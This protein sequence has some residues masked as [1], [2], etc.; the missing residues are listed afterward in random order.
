MWINPKLIVVSGPGFWQT[1]RANRNFIL[2]RRKGRGTQGFS[3]LLVGTWDSVLDTKPPPYRLL[4]QEEGSDTFLMLAACMSGQEA[5]EDWAWLERE[6]LTKVDNFETPSEITDF[7]SGKIASIVAINEVESIEA[8]DASDMEESSGYKAAKVKFHRVFTVPEDEK[9][10][11]YYSCTCWQ[12]RIPAQGWLYLT[13]NH[14]AFYSFI[15][16]SETKILV[17]WTDVTDIEKCG[18]MLLQD[19]LKVSTRQ[20]QWSFS[21]FNKEGYDLIRQLANLGMRKL[22]SEDSYHQDLNL[23]LKRSK[24]VPKKSFL[25]RDLDARKNTEAYRV[26][27]CFPVEEKL[28]GKVE[29]FLF[30]PFNK[31]YRFGTLYLSS[32]FGCFSSHVPGLVS[33]VIPLKDVNCVEKS[34]INVNHGNQDEA[35]V[36]T[37]KNGGKTFVFGQVSDRDFVVEKLCELLAQLKTES[38]DLVSQSSGSASQTS[39]QAS[40]VVGGP[41][42]IQASAD[43]FQVTEPLMTIFRESVDL[44]T[45]AV[46]EIL[47]EKHGAEFGTGISI[48]RTEETTNL[49]SKGIPN[50]WRREVWMTFSGAI[51]DMQRNTGYYAALADSSLQVKSLANDEIERDLHR[52]LPEHPAFQANNKIGIEALR[53]VLSAY[54]ARNPQIGY[55]QAMNIV[56]SVLLIYSSEEEAFW[57]LVAIC[58]RLLPDYYNTKVVGALVDQGVMDH[59]VLTHLPELHA[60]I[61][62]LG[63]LHL[64]SLSWFLTLF[65][66]VMPYHTAVYIIDCFFYEGAKVIFQLALTILSRNSEFLLSCRD[67]GEAMMGLNRY[68]QSI[69]RDEPEL[70][71]PASETPTVIISNLITEAFTMFQSVTS[72]EIESLRLKHRLKVVQTLED[73]QMK[74]VV[75]SVKTVT[76]FSDEEVRALFVVVK[77]EQLI[78]TSKMANDPANQDKLDPSKPFFEL[79]KV[80]HDTWRQVSGLCSSWAKAEIWEVLAHRM[81]KIMDVNQDGFINFKDLLIL[82]DMMSGSDIQRKLKLLYCLHLP[83]VVLPGELETLREDNTEVATDAADFF[84]EAEINLGK[85]A[86]YL[87]E[88]GEHE[89]DAFDSGEKASLNSIQGW[90]IRTDSKLE[91]RKIPPLPQQYFVLLWKSLY[92][93]FMENSLLPETEEQQALYHSVSVVGTL[94]L[95]IGEVGQKF[96]KRKSNLNLEE[97]ETLEEGDQVDGTDENFTGRVERDPKSDSKDWS[98]TFEQF[99]A[100][101][102]TEPVL[103]E[104]FSEKKEL[105]V[106]LK[107][108]NCF[109][110][111]RHSSEEAGSRSVFYV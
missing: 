6:L 34:S 49:I 46:K 57:L 78:R 74:N 40:G 89:E 52:S 104:H 106:A 109:G 22:I 37:M 66:S 16:G 84:I 30:T 85:T 29:C 39:S 67:E 95:Q 20:E 21:I 38:E 11:S 48:Y 27:F 23:L 80:D 100:S 63:M 103:V 45:E 110:L 94:L 69:L 93:L 97:G 102:L 79:Y 47:W 5:L 14:L 9:L 42:E 32:N 12:G 73:S 72:E 91:M 53:R 3:S 54:A 62:D 81:F 24:N 1:E 17:R 64:I 60:K 25:K 51:F 33:L 87:M 107:E 65:L 44:T 83:G 99:L 55:C 26:K 50:K 75:R 71:D 7:V 61:S 43:T 77:N 31:K 86:R 76:K 28:D 58:E 41:V 70:I 4:Y 13:V 10:V 111:R 8:T 92:A 108:Y 35:I 15:L 68:F 101:I 59:L 18:G 36:F 98:I 19:S 2:Q 105:Q 90:L 82:L 96:E 88:A 56:C